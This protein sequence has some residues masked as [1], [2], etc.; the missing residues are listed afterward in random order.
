MIF[1]RTL[2]LSEHESLIGFAETLS[3]RWTNF[4]SRPH[5][6]LIER[7]STSII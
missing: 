3:A 5:F 6:S 7:A 2:C 4:E 1:C